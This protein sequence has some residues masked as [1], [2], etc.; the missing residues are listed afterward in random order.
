MIIMQFALIGAVFNG[1]NVWLGVISAIIV[2]IGIAS[3][4]GF[5][6]LAVHLNK[7]N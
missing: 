2:A 4:P 3:Y 6:L 7:S 1:N 5:G